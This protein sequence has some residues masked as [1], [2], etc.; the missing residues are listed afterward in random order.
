ME[1]VDPFQVPPP[2]RDGVVVVDRD[3]HLLSH[4]GP[5]PSRRRVTRAN[6]VKTDQEIA[7][8]APSFPPP[9]TSSSDLQ[10][11]PSFPPNYLDRAQSSSRRPPV[12]SPSPPLPLSFKMP[13]TSKKS[14]GKWTKGSELDRNGRPA[15]IKR[16]KEV[17]FDQESRKSVPSPPPPPLS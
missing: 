14:K 4:P 6:E 1:R 15:K 13:P 16:V 10:L 3:L 17:V 7:S 9:S 11:K 2:R 5:G 8:L 12:S